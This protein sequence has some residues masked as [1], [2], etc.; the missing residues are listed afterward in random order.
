[1]HKPSQIVVLA[2]VLFWGGVHMAGAK[3][4]E[5]VLIFNARTQKAEEVDKVVKSD[6]EWKMILTPEQF[7]IMREKGTEKPDTRHCDIPRQE[8]I[9]QCAGCATDLFA[10]GRKF[11]SGTGWPSFWEPVSMLNIRTVEDSAFGMHRTEILCARC[12][13]HLGHV[14]DDGPPPTGR[15]YC[16]NSVA[17]VFVPLKSAKLE[18][19]TFAAG[20][21]WGVEEMFRNVKGVVSTKAGYSGGNFDNPTYKDVCSDKTGH[22]E[23][24]EVE[25]D[26]QQVSFEQLLDVFWKIHDPTT[27]NRQGPDVGSQYRSMIFYHS[28]DQEKA[29]R[30][31][32][33]QLEKSGRFKKPVVTE[34]VPAGKFYPAEEYH[35]LYFQKR[36]IKPTCHL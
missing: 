17:L 27:L 32:K 22:A 16:I 20:C 15:R 13:S 9:Y 35:Q 14:F 1:M 8:G 6:A 31:S 7:H 33:E 4:P 18:K 34:I 11:E 28:A 23:T 29:A 24:V 5:K 30:L 3:D 26:P 36:G 19:A 2:L 21:F 12:G 10:A 25:F